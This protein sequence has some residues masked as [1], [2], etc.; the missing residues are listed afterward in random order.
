MYLVKSKKVLIFLLLKT[1]IEDSIKTAI[2]YEVKS[3]LK[4]REYNNTY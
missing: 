1:L 3:F 2:Y 4:I